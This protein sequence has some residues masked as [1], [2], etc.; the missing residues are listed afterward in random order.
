MT[1][2]EGRTG[3][4]ARAVAVTAGVVAALAAVVGCSDDGD[5]SGVDE[6]PVLEVETDTG[7]GVCMQ[8]DDTL[9]AEVETLP[10]VPC[11]QQHSH[12]IYATIESPEEVWPG[13]EELGEFAEVECLEVFEVYVGTSA[14]DSSLSYSWLVPSLESW[15]EEEDRNILCVLGNR[16]GSPLVGSMRG[17]QL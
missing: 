17:Q 8:V 9:P 5:G 11:E 4:V 15:N 1:S 7:E 6:Q 2:R 14:F 10:V 12:E 13:V 16:D 3:S